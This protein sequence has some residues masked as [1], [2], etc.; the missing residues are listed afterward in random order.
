MK[1]DMETDSLR[2]GRGSARRRLLVV[3]PKLHVGGTERHLLQV[4]PRLQRGQFEV[5]VFTTQGPGP[6]DD[7]L[8][9][10]GVTV[11][12]G[13]SVPFSRLR[14]LSAG[15]RLPA[16]MSKLRPDLVHFFLP[17]AY[18][19]GGLAS[20]AFPRTKRVMS[21]RSLNVYQ[22]SRPLVRSLE[23]RLHRSM[24]ALIGNSGAAVQE[25]IA[26]GAPPERIGVILNGIDV[27]RYRAEGKAAARQSLGLSEGSLVLSIIA[28][29]LPYKG[30]A[31]LI[32]ALAAI[33]DRLPAD[34]TLLIAGRDEGLGESLRARAESLGLAN[35]IRWLGE[36][37]D[38]DRLMRAS[39]I[40]L[41]CSH[42]ES[43]PNAVLEGMAAGL[44][45]V[46]TRVGGCPELVDEE[47]TGLLVPARKPEAIGQAISA[48]ADDPA[49]R[50]AMGEA[51]RQAAATRFSLAA[52]VANYESLYTAVLAEQSF[53]V[54]EILS[55]QAQ[56]AT[57]IRAD[58]G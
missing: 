13:P 6:L 44:P 17:E 26:E 9:A 49:R 45:M 1:T 38:P 39:D 47:V 43:L 24:D 21:R 51:A 54:S 41:L 22:R 46:V 31:D 15:F 8:R 48:L 18:I 12:P 56:G 57:T 32:A 23:T 42:E 11:I 2:P 37:G 20:L 10:G 27:D 50:S 3:V 28:T 52:C 4:L 29:L 35:H 40:G 14:A 5:S 7:E 33:R 53:P 16:V 19:I 55:E 58:I 36:V 30:H 34:W 25:L